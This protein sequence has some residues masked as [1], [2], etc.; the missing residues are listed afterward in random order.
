M[1]FLW[2]FASGLNVAVVKEMIGAICRV[3]VCSFFIN[4]V[5]LLPEKQVALFVVRNVL[6]LEVEC[7]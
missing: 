4:A 5:G 1:S 2:L 7:P 3:S 6:L